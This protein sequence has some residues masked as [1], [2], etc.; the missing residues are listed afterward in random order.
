MLR[1]NIYF[2]DTELE[3]AVIRIINSSEIIKT[4][5]ALIELFKIKSFARPDF[6]VESVSLYVGFERNNKKSMCD[7]LIINKIKWY[8]HDQFAQY[9]CQSIINKLSNTDY[10]TTWTASDAFQDRINLIKLYFTNSTDNLLEYIKTNIWSLDPL[11]IN[12]MEQFES[13]IVANI[14]KN[15][16]KKL[17]VEFSSKPELFN[18]IINILYSNK[19]FD[20]INKSELP[21]LLI[22]II[23]PMWSIDVNKLNDLFNNLVDKLKKLGVDINSANKFGYNMYSYIVGLHTCR[24]AR[25]K[26]DISKV[27]DERG[28]EMNK[29]L[30]DAESNHLEIIQKIEALGF[31]N[32]NR[33]VSGIPNDF[34]DLDFNFMVDNIKCT[35]YW[36]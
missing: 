36:G 13:I 26:F 2:D 5:Q 25:T 30:L 32:N 22:D 8:T 31:T 29:T 33:V 9:S 34:T 11:V 18:S 19:L 1:T 35:S 4:N 16:I 23:K 17:L 12:N 24:T 7:A 10:S 15:N 21:D 20:K 27:E 28:I 14:D 3:Q 6:R